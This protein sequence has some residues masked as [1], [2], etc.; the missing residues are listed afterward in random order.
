MYFSVWS[1]RSRELLGVRE[2]WKYQTGAKVA[3]FSEKFKFWS[4]KSFCDTFMVEKVKKEV[5]SRISKKSRF[6]EK[7]MI[8]WPKYKKWDL[9]QSYR[10]NNLFGV[11]IRFWDSF[12]VFTTDLV[13]F[14]FK[15][16]FLENCVFC[17]TPAPD[18]I[19]LKFDP[20]NELDQHFEIDRWKSVFP[21]RCGIQWNTQKK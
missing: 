10:P 16:I 21:K 15:I 3:Y 8:F 4:K 17:R 20:K 2:K 11:R 6:P 13:A 12:H 18:H 1:I 19:L 9:N 5:F 14:Y 7:I